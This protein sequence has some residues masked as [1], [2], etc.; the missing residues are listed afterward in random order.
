MALLRPVRNADDGSLTR[1]V[2]DLPADAPTREE[3]LWA[4]RL[5]D[6]LYRLDNTPWYAKGCALDDLI[7]CDEPP[8]ELPRFRKVVRPSGNRTVRVFIPDT[9]DR[10]A[11]KTEILDLL[12]ELGGLTEE[13]GE[14]KGLIAVTI[15]KAA[16][17]DLVF[18]RLNALEAEK[19]AYWE[20][21][22]F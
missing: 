8:G 4:E 14:D 7:Q 15:P 1:I 9:P 19:R 20:S 3:T 2:V 16:N 21:G 6:Q 12:S 5:G 22:N 11:M 10:A 18:T 17:A 13:F